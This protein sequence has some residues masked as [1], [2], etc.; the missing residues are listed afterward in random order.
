MPLLGV[1]ARRSRDNAGTEARLVVSD[2]AQPR[3]CQLLRGWSKGP[4]GHRTKDD[5]LANPLAR[6]LLLD[7]LALADLADLDVQPE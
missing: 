3:R 1:P 7:A 4:Q 5:E 6:K 2:P